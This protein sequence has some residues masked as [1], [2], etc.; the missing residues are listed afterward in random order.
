ME[1]HVPKQQRN[2]RDGQRARGIVTTPPQAVAAAMATVRTDTDGVGMDWVVGSAVAVA[3]GS[4][5]LS[6]WSQ[7]MVILSWK[8]I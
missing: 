6:T 3:V 2:D 1:E 8:A 5:Y 4:S 7:K